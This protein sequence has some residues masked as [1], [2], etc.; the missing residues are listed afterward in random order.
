MATLFIYSIKVSLCMVTFYFA[1]KM[2]LSRDTFHR[3]NRIAILTSLLLSML[4]PLI[5]INTETQIGIAKGLIV[6]EQAVVT[7]AVVDDE[8]MGLSPV[9][10]GF[11]VYLLGVVL[12]L[13]RE[14]VSLVR[15]GKLMRRGRM[16]GSSALQHDGMPLND[17]DKV[18]DKSRIIVVDDDIS[19]FSWF[20]NIVM[21]SKDF[22]DNPREIINHELAHVRLGHSWDVAFCNFILVFQW[23]NPAAWLLKQELQNIHEYEAD[24]AVIKRGIDAKQYQMLLI[25]KSVGEH[26]FSMANNL[27]HNSL[28]KRITMM[29]KTRTNPW[30]R[31]K[32]LAVLP[33]ATVAI[34]AFASPKVEQAMNRAEVESE[35]MIRMGKDKVATIT[36][37][38]SGEQ[39]V[40]ARQADI[41]PGAEQRKDSVPEKA[42]EVV[43]TM[44]TFPGGIEGLI[45]FLANNIKYPDVAE[46]NNIEGRV[47]VAFV[48]NKTGEVEDPVVVRC[49]SPELD[50]EALRVV[51]AMPKW[52]PGMHKGKPVNVKYTIPISFKLTEDKGG[53][54]ANPESASPAK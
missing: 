22:H 35:G 1:Y 32:A 53:E 48:V 8:S 19:P 47:I 5:K 7:G 46:K 24:E 21:G 39:A 49:V 9:Q 20:R 3:F 44:P 41:M 31:A 50:R 12:F 18:I 29:K 42:Y 40:D 51:R 52:T 11:M 37:L 30:Q 10:W 17:F 26:L 14:V 4:L 34:V 43:E 36:S 16:V 2:L 54:E 27:N 33:I 25:K 38:Q 13:V 45:N 6:I 28:K 15:L 23:F